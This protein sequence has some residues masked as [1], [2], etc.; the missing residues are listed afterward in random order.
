MKQ[1]RPAPGQTGTGRKQFETNPGPARSDMK[2]QV[3]QQHKQSK[4]LPAHPAAALFPL[5]QGEEFRALVADIKKHGLRQRIVTHDGQIL[6]GRNRERACIAAGVEPEHTP[7]QGD[8]PVAFVIS[9]NIHRR[10]LD[11]KQKRD[12]IARLLKMAPEK[13][14]RQVAAAVKASKGTVGA[15]RSEMERRGQIGHVEART[16][17]RGRQQPA[18]KKRLPSKPVTEPSWAVNAFGQWLG[19]ILERAS[20]DKRRD[21]IRG[22]RNTLDQAEA[23]VSKWEEKAQRATGAAEQNGARAAQ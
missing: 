9:A 23:L 5:M 7:F 12:L 15:V 2:Q 17:T 11:A 3:H 14:D 8:D 6:D 19:K 20:A 22:L 16:D 1:K 10:H 4:A 21:V 13:S 18:K